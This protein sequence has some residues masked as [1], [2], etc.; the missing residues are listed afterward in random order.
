MDID[1]AIAIGVDDCSNDQI[2]DSTSVAT[3]ATND[4]VPIFDNSP[5][6]SIGVTMTPRQPSTNNMSAIGN[7]KTKDGSSEE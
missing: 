7:D 2:E 4:A 1:I 3:A 6:R 5:Y